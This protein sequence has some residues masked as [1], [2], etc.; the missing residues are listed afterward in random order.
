MTQP[1]DASLL[2]K[3]Q[4]QA[5]LELLH[6][7]FALAHPGKGL[8]PLDAN[9]QDDAG[10]RGGKRK[11]AAPAPAPPKRANS[12]K[13]NEVDAPSNAAPPPPPPPPEPTPVEA[14]LRAQLQ[15]ARAEAHRARQ[16]AGFFQEERDFYMKKL[17]CIEDA[18]TSLAPEEL[19]PAVIKLLGAD[20]DEVAA[21][22]AALD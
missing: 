7:I 22:S 1:I 18:C 16:E 11:A 12:R 15:D 13:E 21:A 19:A 10:R 3:G 20:E 2:A 14:V 5:T 4:P 17:E 9:A 8:A 6:K